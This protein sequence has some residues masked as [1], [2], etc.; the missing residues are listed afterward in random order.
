MLRF[1]E[2]YNKY[3]DKDFD[4]DEEAFLFLSQSRK[5][6]K[7]AIL[8]FAYAQKA[9]GRYEDFLERRVLK[10]STPSVSIS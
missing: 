2:F 3:R 9:N 6:H 8:C 10:K 5:F 7:Y 4:H 1:H